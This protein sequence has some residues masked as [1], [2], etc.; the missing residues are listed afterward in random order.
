MSRRKAR[1]LAFKMLFAIHEG[2]NTIE[3]A[4]EIVLSSSINEQQKDFIFKEVR[5]TL[6]HLEVIDKTIQKYLSAWDLERLAGTDRNILRLAIYEMLFC[7]DIPV[8]VSINEAVDMAK[9]YCDEQ[10][11]K[12]IN[13]LLGAVAKEEIKRESSGG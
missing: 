3:E 12:Y 5:G 7:E 8:S 9:K 13:G 10:S 11:Y 1:E 4:A 6:E 2:K